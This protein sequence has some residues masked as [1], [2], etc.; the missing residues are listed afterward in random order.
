MGNATRGQPQATMDHADIRGLASA[1]HRSVAGLPR[2]KVGDHPGWWR[3]ETYEFDMPIAKA[4]PREESG[5]GTEAAAQLI[6]SL[7]W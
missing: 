3:H 5:D 1:L 4:Q 7:S 6:L 2:F